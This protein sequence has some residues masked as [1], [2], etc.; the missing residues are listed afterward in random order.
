MPENRH[1]QCTRFPLYK[2]GMSKQAYTFHKTERP[3]DKYSSGNVD[4]CFE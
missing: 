2:I 3:F 1:T 4:A